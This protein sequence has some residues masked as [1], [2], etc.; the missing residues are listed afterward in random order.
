M[1]KMIK[2]F[3]RGLWD[4]HPTFRIMIGMCPTLA[5]TTSAINGMGMA[6]AT[7]FVL[8]CSS[9]LISMLKKVIPGGVRIPAYIIVI[10]TF[11]TTVDY[12]MQAYTPDLHEAL[13]V[14]IPLIVVNCIILGRAEAYASKMPVIWSAFDALGMGL[15]FTWGLTL[16]GSIRELLGSGTIFGFSVA[17]DG[18]TP[19][20]ILTSPPGAFI[21]LGV[22]LALMN[23]I[24][25]KIAQ[26]TRANQQTT[27]S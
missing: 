13:G 19:F 7:T 6:I 11:V 27:A 12:L 5:V 24:S 10:A 14:F 1:N 17:P 3:L 4:E 8:I 9:L 26:R 15:G 2:D 20:A 16:I 22:L 21:T 23:I 25:D 18:F